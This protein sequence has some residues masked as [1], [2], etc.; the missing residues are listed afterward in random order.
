MSTTK[1]TPGPWMVDDEHRLNH[2]TY[3]IHN[4]KEIVAYGVS[5]KNMP[6]VKSAPDLLEALEK[7][8]AQ[9]A[10]DCSIGSDPKFKELCWVHTQAMQAIKKAKP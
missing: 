9:V 5:A 4:G 3:Q 8:T 6:L 10:M 7:L 1:H 2:E